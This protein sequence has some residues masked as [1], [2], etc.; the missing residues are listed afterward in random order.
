MFEYYREVGADAR[1]ASARPAVHDEALP[2][3]DRRRGVL[4]EAGAEGDCRLDPHAPVPHVPARRRFAARRFP[5]AEFAEAVLWM[6][7]MNCVDMNAWYSRVDKPRPSGLR[8]LRSRS[9]GRR[10]RARDRGRAPD[11]RAA[12]RGRAAGIREDERRRRHPR[13][14]ADHAPFDV[15]A[16]LRVR[17]ARLPAARAEPSRQ[18]DDGVA[19]EEA[20]RRSRRPPPERL[21]EDDRIRV[22]GAPEARRARVDAA[23]MGGATVPASA[24]AISGWPS[25][26]TGSP[27]TVTCSR[28]CWRTRR[29]LA[30]AAKK[31]ERL[32]SN[33]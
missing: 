10:L 29:P 33:E 16:D 4:P 21:G 7:Q 18:G 28:R 12:R 9:A 32:G 14:R 13:R 31:L 3:R 19:E 17:R 24:R 27:S 22:L 20:E 15:R 11:P 30:P 25:R 5:A 2:A 8:P 26:W 1:P 6:V 23:A